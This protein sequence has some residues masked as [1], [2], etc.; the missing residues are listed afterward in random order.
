L[1]SGRGSFA[2]GSGAAIA[3]TSAAV[4][5][6]WSSTWRRKR[7]ATCKRRDIAGCGTFHVLSNG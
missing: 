3:M 7:G 6:I 1:Q 4:A 5:L 2:L